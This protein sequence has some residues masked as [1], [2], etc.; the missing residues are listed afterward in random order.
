MVIIGA[1]MLAIVRPWRPDPP[2]DDEE[3]A[4]PAQAVTAR[5]RIDAHARRPLPVVKRH[6]LQAIAL[7]PAARA[8]RLPPAPGRG[9]IVLPDWLGPVSADKLERK[10]ALAD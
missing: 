6:H 4:A 8:R 2:D 9:E 1:T 5:H 10:R 3:P 7:D